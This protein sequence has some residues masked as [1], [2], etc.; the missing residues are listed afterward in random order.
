MI[1]AKKEPIKLRKRKIKLR[2]VVH[3]ISF[4]FF[5]QKYAKK[6]VESRKHK[7]KMFMKQSFHKQITIMKNWLVETQK[8]PITI[9]LEKAMLD[10]KFF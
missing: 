8:F 2:K 6:S 5:L 4:I 7:T 1:A 9:L 3:C 10:F